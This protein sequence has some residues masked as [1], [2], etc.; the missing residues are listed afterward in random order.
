MAKLKK[1][2]YGIDEAGRGPL[3]GPVS[4]GMFSIE[5]THLLKGIKNS[6]ALSEQKREE[7]FKYFQK[8]RCKKIASYSYSMVSN[9]IIDKFGISKAIKIGIKRCIKKIGC[10]SGRSHILL[11]GSLYAPLEFS[12]KTII[13][14][15]EKIKIISAASIIAKVYRDRRM[16]KYSDIFPAYSFDVHKGYGTKNHLNAIKKHGVSHLH[17]KSYLRKFFTK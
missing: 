8:L 17:R 9:T 4:I 2:L 12:Q 14:G 13:K 1:I 16:K 15:D 10:D 3:A 11:D 5:K 6:K 7:W